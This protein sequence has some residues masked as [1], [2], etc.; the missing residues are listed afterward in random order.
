[1][2]GLSSSR[3]VWSARIATLSDGLRARVLPSAAAVPSARGR[4]RRRCGPDHDDLGLEIAQAEALDVGEAAVGVDEELG[5]DDRRRDHP[6]ADLLRRI[7]QPGGHLQALAQRGRRLRRLDRVDPLQESAAVAGVVGDDLGRSSNLMTMARSSAS[8]SL[9]TFLAACLG[10]RQPAGRD[11]GRGHARRAIDQEH[12]PLAL[13][14]ASLHAR[15]GQGEHRQRHRQKLQKQEQVAPQ[16]LKQTVDVQVFQAPP[17]QDRAR[18]PD[19]PPAQL[20]EIKRDD[21]DRHAGQH[22]PRRQSQ[23]RAE[24]DR[25]AQAAQSIPEI[26]SWPSGLP[27]RS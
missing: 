23:W 7:R 4:I 20:E 14:A 3:R 15:A 26:A 9:T 5:R 24:L 25:R 22:E 27:A 18:H 2:S 13:A 19:R 11:V 10:F 8:I 6:L 16:S 21:P 17:P 12:E 1:M